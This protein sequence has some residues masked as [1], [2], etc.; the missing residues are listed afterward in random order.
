MVMRNFHILSNV[1]LLFC[2]CLNINTIEH[3]G[4]EYIRHVPPSHFS[5]IISKGFK[6]KIHYR[7]K[8]GRTCPAMYHL[9]CLETM[10]HDLCKQ[11]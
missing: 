10:R 9:G 6:G 3:S 5:R 7:L 1:I 2:L 4:H 8:A 11:N